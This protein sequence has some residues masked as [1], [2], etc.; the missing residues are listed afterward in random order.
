M[1]KPKYAIG[2][3]FLFLLAMTASAQSAY[4][5]QVG[6]PFPDLLLPSLD[7]GKPLS[8]SNFRG[9]K[10]ILHVFASW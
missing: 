7:D 3:I 6:E 4:R 5:I 10:V 8:V 9:E 1:S 2:I